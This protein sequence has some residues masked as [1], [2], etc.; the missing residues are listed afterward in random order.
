MTQQLLDQFMAA[1]LSGLVARPVPQDQVVKYLAPE[2]AAATA[3]VYAEAMLL[4]R[5]KYFNAQA[6]KQ[7]QAREE[8]Q[9]LLRERWLTWLRGILRDRSL[10]QEQEEWLLGEY[11]WEKGDWEQWDGEQLEMLLEDIELLSGEYL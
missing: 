8:N 5:E 11:P 7:Q 2:V 4:A 9:A 10:T 3:L 1:A 6:A